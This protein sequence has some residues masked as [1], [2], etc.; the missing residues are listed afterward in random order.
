MNDEGTG[1]RVACKVLLVLIVGST[2][3]VSLAPVQP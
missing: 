3:P 1:R 2:Q